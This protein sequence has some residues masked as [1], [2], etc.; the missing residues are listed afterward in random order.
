MSA[1]R[2]DRAALIV[3]VDH[4]ADPEIRDLTCAEKDCV[5]L[6]GLLHHR[7]GFEPVKWLYGDNVTS[8][9]LLD[10]ASTMARELGPGGLLF[11]YFAGHAVE[12]GGHHLLLCPQARYAR[13]AFMQ[14]AVAV[15]LLRRETEQAG[16]NRVFV[17]DACRSDLLSTRGVGAQGL[18]GEQVLR[19]VVAHPEQ[20]SKA[21]TGSLAVL[22]SCAE[23][24]QAGEL[25]ASG[26]GLF[27]KALL[28]EINDSIKSG[29]ELAADDRMEKAVIDRMGALARR[30]GLH[31]TQRPWIVRSGSPPVII[32]AGATSSGG[33]AEG[34]EAGRTETA[35]TAEAPL[36]EEAA[37]KPR[38]SGRAI[39]VVAAAVVVF[40]LLAVL[41]GIHYAR[42]GNQDEPTMPT[43]PPSQIQKAPGR[44]SDTEGG[45]NRLRVKDGWRQN[46]SGH[47]RQ[48]SG[49]PTPS[50][51]DL[52]QKIGEYMPPVEGGALEIAAPRDWEWA[53]PVDDY[54]VQFRQKGATLND[55]PRILVDVEDSPFPELTDVDEQ[56]IDEFVKNVSATVDAAKLKEPVKPIILGST[57]CATYVDIAKQGNARDV[58]TQAVKTLAG[59]RLYTIRLEAFESE[60][61]TYRD[62]GYAVVASMKFGRRHDP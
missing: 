7:A 13:L 31:T 4:Y 12:H 32:P 11:F 23:G 53:R 18:T 22:C 43:S 10:T 44:Q 56:N 38:M 20:V 47:Q 42:V 33:L 52:E 26:H 15:D 3:G 61:N 9:K 30:S 2:T 51:E 17:L 6:Q 28:D 41:G 5:E 29:S 45:E 60:F 54:L 58:A 57:M 27:T 8:E 24:Q 25:V 49:D 14:Q 37:R 36:V 21:Q 19:D 59:G 46:W 1:A 62:M 16:L 40:A 34:A 39:V 50:T 55:L 48:H 35:A